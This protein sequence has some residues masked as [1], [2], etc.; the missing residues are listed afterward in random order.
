MFSTTDSEVKSGKEKGYRMDCCLQL[1]LQEFI[2]RVFKILCPTPGGRG[3]PCTDL[4]A[5][6]EHFSQ[7]RDPHTRPLASLQLLAPSK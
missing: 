1:L 2:Q 6:S 4:E 7:H 3:D 5:V